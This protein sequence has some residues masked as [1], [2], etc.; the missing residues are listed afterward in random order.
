M[1]IIII[2]TYELSFVLTIL[3]TTMIG[4]IEL[5]LFYFVDWADKTMGIL[6]KITGAGQNHWIGM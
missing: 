5:Y 6:S 2:A 4:V 3:V 1:I